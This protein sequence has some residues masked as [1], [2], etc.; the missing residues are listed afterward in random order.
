MRRFGVLSATG[1]RAL[2]T[3]GVVALLSTATGARPMQDP[4]AQP[5]AQEAADGLKLNLDSP[6]LI[7]SFVKRDKAADFEAGWSMIKQEI[8]AST[9]PEVKEFGATLS[10]SYKVDGTLAGQ[11]PPAPTAPVVYVL[12][13]DAPSKTQ[14]YNPTKVIYEL[15]HMNGKEGG[16]SRARADEIFGK[17]STVYEQILVWP[18]VK[19]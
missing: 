17:L 10:K 18:L 19:G 12:Q 9:R 1:R 5:A 4:P 16:I 2:V 7:V 14:S 3:T 13:L 11:P 8:E 6:V 15:L